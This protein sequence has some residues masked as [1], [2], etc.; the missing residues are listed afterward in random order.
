M[1]E[2]VRLERIRATGLFRYTLIMEAAD[3]TLNRRQRGALARE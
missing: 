3:P 2:Q 1:D